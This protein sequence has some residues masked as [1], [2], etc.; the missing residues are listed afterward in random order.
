MWVEITSSSRTGGFGMMKRF[1]KWLC[2]GMLLDEYL[3]G[4]GHGVDQQ[5]EEPKSCEHHKTL[6]Y[7]GDEE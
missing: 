1:L 7:W 5:R 6:N 3:R 4:W 2:S